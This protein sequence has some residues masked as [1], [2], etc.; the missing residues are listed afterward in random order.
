MFTPRGKV[1]IDFIRR[2]PPAD[3][4]MVLL[5]EVNPED[6]PFLDPGR[7]MVCKL[8]TAG[9][10]RFSTGGEKFFHHGIDALRLAQVVDPG[11]VALDSEDAMW[12]YRSR[13]ELKHYTTM[14]WEQWERFFLSPATKHLFGVDT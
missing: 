12:I 9:G 11:T 14:A 3:E 2:R 10:P 1:K 8:I 13:D 6:P 5:T 4:G 7:L